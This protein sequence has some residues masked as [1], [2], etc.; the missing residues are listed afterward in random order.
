MFYLHRATGTVWV[1]DIEMVKVTPDLEHELEQEKV[2]EL[3]NKGIDQVRTQ[4]EILGDADAQAA[5]DAIAE[6]AKGTELPSD[7][8]HRAGPPYYPLHA[9][10]FG[11]MAAL[12]REYSGAAEPV[13]AWVSDPFEPMGALQTVPAER[14]MTA[15]CLMGLDERD[16]C[17]VNLSN[18]GDAPVDVQISVDGLDGDGAPTIT[19]REMCCIDPGGGGL[20]P[21]PLPLLDE[22]GGVRT[23]T[24]PPGRLGGVWLDISSAG[25]A[26]GTYATTVRIAPDGGDEMRVPVSIEVLPL[27]MPEEKP[28]TTWGYSYEYYWILPEVW[29]LAAPDLAA[30]HIDA[31]CWPSRYVPF[32]ELDDDGNL[33]TLDWTTFEAGV[34]SH[35]PMR[36]LLLW[37]GFE[38][39]GNLELRLGLEPGSAEWKRVARLWFR[40]L[41]DGLDERG[42]GTDRV[43]WYLTDEAISYG[44]A[45]ATVQTGAILNEVSPESLVMS[46]PYPAAPWDLLRQMDPV[47]N[48]WCPSLSFTD[49]EHLEFF[50]EGSDI[51]WTYQVLGKGSDPFAQHR[52][53]FWDCWQKGLTG[54]GFWCYADAHGSNWDP[55]DEG[56][57]DY[58]PV[59]EGDEREMIPSLRWEAWRE[60][61]EDYTYLW[62]LRQRMQQDAGTPQVRETARELIEQLPGQVLASGTPEALAEARR[63]VLETLVA[64]GE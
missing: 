46:N 18:I 51:L 49:P 26:A 19:L 45:K 13:A 15:G 39:Q 16:Q 56:R 40:A 37:P 10:V 28:I 5:L 35:P 42:F 62:M 14:E 55:R 34:A 50:R 53:S 24:L 60:G 25:A 52:L 47:V 8:D 61:V 44:K 6:R 3:L 22:V 12:N 11:V 17:R 20:K 9:E 29:H 57:G 63:R 64:L 48:L 58:S 1:D 36:W 4:A 21:D 43:A 41:V 7:V 59:Y 31:Y 2:Y 38:W 30:H 54:Q 27:R 23:I 32:P 33:Q